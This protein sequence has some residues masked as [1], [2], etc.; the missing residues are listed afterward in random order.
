MRCRAFCFS[1]RKG[2][3]HA[4]IRDCGRR[5]LEAAS[6]PG[7]AE[8]RQTRPRQREWIGQRLHPCP[9]GRGAPAEAAR[10]SNGRGG[11]VSSTPQQTPPTSEAPEIVAL[12]V[13]PSQSSLDVACRLAVVRT[14]AA[15]EA[16]DDARDCLGRTMDCL[17]SELHSRSIFLSDIL[18]ENAERT[19]LLA[20]S[21]C[22]AARE[23][24][25]Q[26][27]KE[28]RLARAEID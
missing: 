5:D 2:Q 26:V 28:R 20:A 1:S 3:L 21:R 4:V 7:G 27:R 10:R 8:A 18:L 9:V 15:A 14:V 19:H 24:V 16:T 17:W 11:P 22:R 6:R 23:S 12:Q 25:E 13:F